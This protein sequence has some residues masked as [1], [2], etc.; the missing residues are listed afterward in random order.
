V[1]F[2]NTTMGW[3]NP[4][5]PLAIRLQAYQII[6]LYD[7][8]LKFSLLRPLYYSL[9]KRIT[10]PSLQIQLL[11]LIIASVYLEEKIICKGDYEGEA[12]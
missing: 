5:I 6:I 3:R 4:G 11:F 9:L 8:Y 1:S 12:L 2:P 10:N 7:P